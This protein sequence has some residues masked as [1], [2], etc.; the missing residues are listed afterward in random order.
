MGDVALDAALASLALL[1]SKP[2]TSCLLAYEDEVAAAWAELPF[3]KA[4]V[5]DDDLS[6]VVV[7]RIAPNLTAVTL[8]SSHAFSE[9]AAAVYGA[10]GAAARVAG[11]ATDADVERAVLARLTS[12]AER[13]LA[14]WL[15]PAHIRTPAWG[16]HLHRW[17]AAF[18][19][20]QLLPEQ[21]IL[22]QSAGVAFAGDFVEH[23]RAGS[24]EGAALSGL[25]TAAALT[26]SL[27]AAGKL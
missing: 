3:A 15:Q 4:M 9:D 24:V 18:P 16:P 12:A 14:R 11:A 22:V 10:T 23:P 6:R 26:T 20:A 5:E 17:G 19:D 27:R 7:K 13:R 8:H 2:V 1:R 25:R 21:H